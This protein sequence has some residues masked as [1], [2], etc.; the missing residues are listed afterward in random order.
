M[1]ATLYEPLTH[2]G[3]PRV[4]TLIPWARLIGGL[5]ALPA[6]IEIGVIVVGGSVDLWV[7]LADE[8]DDTEAE[9]SRLERDFRV[10][11]GPV[12]FELH[13]APLTIVNRDNVP[14]FETV[15]SR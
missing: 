13:L 11:V 9:V 2:D 8:D 12:P 6:V 5:S 7:L 4:P 3:S 14:P 10:A 15:F 1:I